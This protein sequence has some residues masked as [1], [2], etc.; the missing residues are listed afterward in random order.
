MNAIKFFIP[1]VGKL[2]GELRFGGQKEE[3]TARVYGRRQVIS[4]DYHL[5]CSARPDLDVVV[6]LPE[7]AGVKTFDHRTPVRL[8]DPRMEP[9]VVGENVEYMLFATDIVRV[10]R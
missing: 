10:D 6:R 2:F 3:N 9:V 7:K 5:T 8:V 1:K 4:R